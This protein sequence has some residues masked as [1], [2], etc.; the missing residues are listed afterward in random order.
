MAKPSSGALPQF[1]RIAETLTIDIGTGRLSPGDRLPPERDMAASYGVSVTT[2][3]KSLA[4][5][6][7]RGLL[8]RKQGSGNYITA[9]TPAVG[10][11]AMF[12]LERA[13]RGGGLP[14][15]ELLSFARSVFPDF[16]EDGAGQAAWTIRRLRFLDGIP[17]AIEEIWVGAEL[18]ADLTAE[19]LSESL[20][21]TY[22][23]RCDLHI[24]K[25]EDRVGV[26]PL[27]DWSPP[28]LDVAP[29]AQMGL[30]ERRAFDGYGRLAEVSRTWFDPA[31]ARYVARVP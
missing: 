14:T 28:A 16:A 22:R 12:R 3:R 27:P 15:A 9:A 4:L 8:S 26:A 17:G 11:Y 23:D 18:A 6:E 10:T 25:A 20:Y 29:T 13:D 19:T 5:L 7:E 31:R 30:V 24:A 1:L 2:L 21:K